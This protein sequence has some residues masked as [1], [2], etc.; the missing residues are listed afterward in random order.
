MKKIAIVT[1]PNYSS[2]RILANCLQAVFSQTEGI[3][4]EVFHKLF[5]FKR[6]LEYKR[7]A[8]NYNFLH[9]KPIN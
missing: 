8:K 9:G 4:S 3:Q 5:V 2:P 7:V 1:K 6:L